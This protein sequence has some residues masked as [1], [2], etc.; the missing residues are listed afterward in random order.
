[1]QELVAAA[2]DVDAEKVPSRVAA[3]ALAAKHSLN[4]NS[5]RQMLDAH[6]QLLRGLVFKGTLSA[7]ILRAFLAAIHERGGAAL[8]GTALRSLALHMEYWQSQYGGPKREFQQIAREFALLAHEQADSAEAVPDVD[9]EATE[10]DPLLVTRLRRERDPAIRRK[11]CDAARVA[12]GSLACEACG[13]N[14]RKLFPQLDVDLREVHHRAALAD[15]GGGDRDSPCGRRCAVPQ[16]PPRDPPP[17]AA[18]ERGA[19]SLARDRPLG[20]PLSSIWPHS[21]PLSLAHAGVLANQA[22]AVKSRRCLRVI[23]AAG[24]MPDWAGLSAH[25]LRLECVR[26]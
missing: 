24:V 3:E 25:A 22:L 9:Y 12:D 15:T 11:K 1:V 7:Q 10:G 2:A 18:A 17:A 8:L 23:Y 4:I 20:S 13:T 21:G 14:S 26:R 5:V 16:L 6:R 19:V